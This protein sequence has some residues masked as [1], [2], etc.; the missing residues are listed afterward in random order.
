MKFVKENGQFIISLSGRVDSSNAESVGAELMETIAGAGS[1]SVVLDMEELQY[2]SSAGLRV[3][4]RLRKNE[5][6]LK[7]VN[8][9]S[10]VYGPSKFQE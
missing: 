6:T 8:A 2:I 5:P 1:D 9:S 3:L 7:V 4:L 10:E